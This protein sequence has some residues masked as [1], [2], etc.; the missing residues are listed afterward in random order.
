MQIAAF[1][2]F[3][4]APQRQYR[5][6]HTVTSIR[7]CDWHDRTARNRTAARAQDPCTGGT[8]A[9]N[10]SRIQE[11]LADSFGWPWHH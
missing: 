8:P 5:Y 4:S 7:S 1:N 9:A 3:P 10:K 11:R 2:H 6:A